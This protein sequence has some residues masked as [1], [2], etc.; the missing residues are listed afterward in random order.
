MVL[1]TKSDYSYACQKRAAVAIHLLNLAGFKF[2]ST[3]FSNIKVRGAILNHANLEGANF[4]GADLQNA[5]LRG[6][7]LKNTDF[8]NTNLLGAFFTDWET[9]STNQHID[10]LC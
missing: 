8:T 6:A 2:D 4:T 9:Y 7:K 1:Q 10:S 3:D 5:D